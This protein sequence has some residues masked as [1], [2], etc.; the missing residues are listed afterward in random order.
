[1]NENTP[2]EPESLSIDDFLAALDMA[3]RPD[4]SPY[5]PENTWDEVKPGLWLGGTHDEHDLR[6]QAR[7]GSDLPQ[8][9]PEEFQTIVTMYAWAMPADWFVK[10]LRY[11]IYDGDMSDF[12][13]T[14]LHELVSTAHRDW[15]A[16]KKVLIRCQAGI[17]RSGLIMALVLI[18]DGMQPEEAIELMRQKRAR[19]VLRNQTFE[20]WLK[21][22]DVKDW[23]A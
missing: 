20:N 22:V 2:K 7:Y 15:K 14:D 4:Q 23:R 5:L 3:K 9:T 6:L 13:T 12:D 16:G 18:R 21:Q 19:S 17:N 11:G 1:M 8:I 10:E